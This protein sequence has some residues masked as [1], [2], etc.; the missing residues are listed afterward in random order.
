MS[1]RTREFAELLWKNDTHSRH[2]W[3]NH[4][5]KA[6]DI[7][8]QAIRLSFKASGLDEWEMPAFIER[9]RVELELMKA[10]AKK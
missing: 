9:L 2:P 8:E 4:E 1:D 5:V 6:V 10:E 7:A 3:W